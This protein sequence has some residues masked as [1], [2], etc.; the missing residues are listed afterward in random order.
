MNYEPLE[1]IQNEVVYFLFAKFSVQKL[2]VTKIR[3]QPEAS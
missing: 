3:Q 1:F 2:R